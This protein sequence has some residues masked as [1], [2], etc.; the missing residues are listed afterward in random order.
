MTLVVDASVVAEVLLGTSRGLRA[1]E[2]W[3]SHQLV[4][5]DHLTV[6]VASVIRGWSLG[7]H[8]SDEQAVRALAELAELDIE[9]LDMAG[10][11]EEVWALRHN[12]TAYDAMYVALAGALNTTVLTLDAKLVGLRDEVVDP[13]RR[14]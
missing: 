7:G 9:C 10:M 2:M 13:Q 1:A 14:L 3:G 4:A 12:L 5:P 11:V 8:L 6:E